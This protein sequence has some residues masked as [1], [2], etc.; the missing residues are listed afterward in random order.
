M[1]DYTNAINQIRQANALCSYDW[2]LAG[3]GP[4]GN[5]SLAYLLIQLRI[6]F[7][8]DTFHPYLFRNLVGSSIGSLAL[9]AY[10]HVYY[11]YD[12]GETDAAF[13][14]IDVYVNGITFDI[15]RGVLSGEGQN[16]PLPGVFDA[17]GR[18]IRTGGVFSNRIL[19]GIVTLESDL[20]KHLKHYFETDAFFKWLSPKLNNLFVVIQTPANNVEHIFTGNPMLLKNK[21]KLIKFEQLTVANIDQV[22]LSSMSIPTVYESML[23]PGVGHTIDG[24]TY[25]RNAN[26]IQLILHNLTYCNNLEQTHRKMMEFFN[27]KTDNFVIYVD[28][29]NTQNYYENVVHFTTSRVKPVNT[30]LTWMQFIPRTFRNGHRNYE[31]NAVTYTQPFVHEFSTLNSNDLFGE[32]YHEM[33]ATFAQPLNT[34][35]LFNVRTND[36]IVH[37]QV[38][39]KQFK[40]SLQYQITNDY[41]KYCENQQ[42][43]ESITSNLPISTY[44]Y[45]NR[46]FVYK[47]KTVHAIVTNTYVRSLYAI[48]ENFEAACLL[49]NYK[50][51]S[52]DLQRAIGIVQANVTYNFY[53]KRL[54][55]GYNSTLPAVLKR[56]YD[57]FVGEPNP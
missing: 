34:S 47:G 43:Y 53:L 35:K 50:T 27:V 18:F 9:H 20:F 48:N 28:I 12:I 15:M 57:G 51:N 38:T 23:I 40:H 8:N 42:Y 45:D 13:E 21:S 37:E 32:K 36:I 46:A 1:R 17:V 24:S 55:T 14:L 16:K 7:K 3:D 31:L 30:L 2:T 4:F 5:G 39:S 11:L 22:V 29:V 41:T 54:A 10:L 19:R 6:H 52:F 56:A 49:V 25:I 26:H 44:I 33:K